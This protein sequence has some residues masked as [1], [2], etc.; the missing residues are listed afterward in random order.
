MVALAPSAPVPASA[1]PQTAARPA[2]NGTSECGSVGDLI[3]ILPAEIPLQKEEVSPSPSAEP[4]PGAP[5]RPGG[6]ARPARLARWFPC[7]KATPPLRATGS[8]G[9][10]CGNSQP[11][12]APRKGKSQHLPNPG[13]QIRRP[14]PPTHRPRCACRRVPP[15]RGS[16]GSAGSLRKSPHQTASRPGSTFLPHRP[17]HSIRRPRF[18]QDLCPVPRPRHHLRNPRDRASWVP[19]TGMHLR[20]PDAR[21]TRSLGSPRRGRPETPRSSKRPTPARVRIPKKSTNCPHRPRRES[22]WFDWPWWA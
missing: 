15:V 21:M 3:P 4:A 7:W 1:K 16:P 10:R 17:H 13:P 20:H 19:E 22:S 18:R 12:R 8:W 9:R 11:R 5:G 6:A 2:R 14:D